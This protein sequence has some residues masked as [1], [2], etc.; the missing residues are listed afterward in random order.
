MINCCVHSELHSYIE[1]WKSNYIISNILGAFSKF[2]LE[3]EN[4]IKGLELIMV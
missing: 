3:I 1:K 4:V 2:I